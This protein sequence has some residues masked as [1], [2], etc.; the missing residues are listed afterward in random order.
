MN[1]IVKNKIKI[2]IEENVEEVFLT[3][4]CGLFLF[5]THA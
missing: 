4:M 1:T 2:M 3:D 5:K